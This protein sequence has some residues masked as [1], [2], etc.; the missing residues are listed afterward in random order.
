MKKIFLVSVLFILFQSQT[1]SQMNSPAK[2]QI[3]GFEQQ[4]KTANESLDKGLYKTAEAKI[5]TLEKMLET[6][7]KKDPSYNTAELEQK[8][9]DFK[10]KCSKESTEAQ[11]LKA[12]TKEQYYNNIKIKDK[13]EIIK[14][15]KSLDE[16]TAKELLALDISTIDMSNYQK[17]VEE[18]AA[19]TINNDLPN[20]KSLMTEVP[21]VQEALIHYNKFVNQKRYWQTMSTL[22]PN[23]TIIKETYSKFDALDKEI[24][25]EAGI[26]ANAKAQYA[27]YLKNKKMPSAVTKDVTAENIIKKAYED[28][29]KKQGYNRTLLK[30][31]L[32]ENDWTILT[33]KYT[34]VIVGRKRAA[35]IAFKDNNTGECYLYRFFEVYQQYNGSGYSNGEGTST[36]EELIPCENVK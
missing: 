30:I 2:I 16:A 32:L 25:G 17:V 28:E 11:Q 5:A 26:K 12:D 3:N 6:I 21:I 9:N 20:I 24:G 27:E 23:S 33:N 36:T 10:S 15:T 7:K 14:N 34:S 22:I 13:L 31:N 4:L 18:Y 35:A 8:L 1:F 19:T 29:G